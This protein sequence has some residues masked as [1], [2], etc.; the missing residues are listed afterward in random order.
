M[1]DI[2]CA[3]KDEAVVADRQ[4][5][6]Q[7]AARGYIK[8]GLST[9]PAK[10]SDKRPTVYWKPYQKQLPTYGVF[11]V[12]SD[13]DAVCIITGKVSG[14]LIMIDF[15]QQAKAYPQWA[16]SVPAEL[17][18]RCVIERSQR[19]GK[20]V[21][22]RCT[23]AV[24]K[25]DKLALDVDG[26][27]LIE[28]RG[29][30]GLFLCAPTEGYEILQGD[31][32]AMPVLTADEVETLLAAA[33]ALN[34]AP[35]KPKTKPIANPVATT[36]EPY[37][38]R[39]L[40]VLVAQSRARK[41]I[42]KMPPAIQGQGGSDALYRVCCVLFWDFGL[43]PSQGRDILGQYNARCVPPWSDEELDHKMESALDPANKK[44]PRGWR[45]GEAEPM[46]SKAQRNPPRLIPTK[47][48]DH[49]ARAPRWLWEGRIALGELTLVN[50]SPGAGKTTFITHLCAVV[51]SGGVFADGTRCAKSGCVLYLSSETSRDVF[52]AGLNAGGAD[53]DKIIFA[54]TIAAENDRGETSE[55]LVR[56]RD[57]AALDVFIAEHKE[58]VAV[59]FDPVGSFLGGD[60]DSH[61]DNEV[62]NELNPIGELAKRHAIAVIAVTH[63]SKS[64]RNCT[65]ADE[66]I[67][68]S[69]GIAGIARAVWHLV[70][71]PE[72]TEDG[73]HQRILAA[74]KMNN[75]QPAGLL[76]FRIE[77]IPV[78]A[79]KS[80]DTLTGLCVI[81]LP[82]EEDDADKTANDVFR[83]LR[84][85]TNGL[86]GGHRHGPDP[87]RRDE[88]MEWL[89]EALSQAD[90]PFVS[91]TELKDRWE[92]E[93]GALR[94]LARAKASLD[95]RH[96]Q[97]TIDG[98]TFSIWHLPTVVVA[99]DGTVTAAPEKPI[100]PTAEC[101]F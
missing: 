82:S 88:A 4:A 36:F 32:A 86:E 97:V 10:R 45:L 46:A 59:I 40:D 75:A 5:V 33:R 57:A 8:S 67:L 54:E 93:G 71:D 78:L 19:G 16:A 55:R 52:W 80:G 96:R 92:D 31:F 77:G 47:M 3:Q 25:N 68:G 23:V 85:A 73:Y 99:K 1:T 38:A 94:T 42:A 12:K 98:K 53:L 50:G 95:V 89:Q 81:P 17:L 58:I 14:N 48:S 101:P 43:S 69:T 2:L 87:M 15:D 18:A 76:R 11:C 62:R 63:P 30:G 90:K 100:D 9:L 64:G 20:H 28:T 26:G 61:R 51:S 6:L 72:K 7:T 44:K 22:V 34:E 41:Y 29:E 79:A 84:R 27:V 66:S 83:E 13:F 35:P 70:T 49:E 39:S 24:G 60:I 91:A 65:H 37:E 74:G 21:V 56:F